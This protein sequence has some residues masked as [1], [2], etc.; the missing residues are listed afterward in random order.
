M[1][2]QQQF[3]VSA[4]LVDAWAFFQDVPTV[5]GCMPGVERIDETGPGTFAGDVKL[6][7]GPLSFRLSGRLVQQDVDDATHSAT[8]VLTAED[9]AL[10]SGVSATL[11]LRLAEDSGQATTVTLDT[12]A[13]VVG[14]LGQFGQGVIKLTADGIL[15]QFAACAR[16][17]LAQPESVATAV[18]ANGSKEVE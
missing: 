4:P 10:A 7:V 9:R 13:N 15:K 11:R 3:T 2:L 6:R 14:K 12:D 18:H 5:A 17:R 1:L 8:L 16:Q